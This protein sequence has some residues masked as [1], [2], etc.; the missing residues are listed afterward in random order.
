MFQF[1]AISAVLVHVMPYLS[2]IG[3]ARSNSSLV[4]SAI[5]VVSIF[6]RLGFGWIGDRFDKKRVTTAT[7][8]LTPLGLFFFSY[9]ANGVVWLIIPFTILFSIGWGSQVTMTV[10]LAAEHFG[11][12][13]FGTVFGFIHGILTLGGVIGP[14]LAGWA[15]DKW[16]SYQGIWFALM[17]L[18]AATVA[19][20]TT[21]PPAGD[22]IKKVDKKKRRVNK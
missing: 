21:T 3:V 19:V 8:L 20:I 22:I 18:T 10:A 5:L 12:W 6:G 14:L 4:A 9:A 7:F 1:L 16:G 17:G 13:R 2:S 11:R 15:F